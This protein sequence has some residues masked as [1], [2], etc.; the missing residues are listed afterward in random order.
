MT[1]EE[2]LEKMTGDFITNLINHKFDDKKK[3][4]EL[5]MRVCH[6]INAEQI[7]Q[8]DQAYNRQLM[9]FWGPLN[10]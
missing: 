7:W 8:Q 3:Y 9:E 6:L 2:K 5:A 10:N 1:D 4:A